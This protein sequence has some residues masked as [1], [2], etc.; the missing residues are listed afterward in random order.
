MSV[1]TYF[2]VA[3]A[4]LSFVAPAKTRFDIIA[5][6]YPPFSSSEIPGGGLT[7]DLLRNQYGENIVFKP[8]F[9]P[10]ARAAK[11]LATSDWCGS[12]FPPGEQVPALKWPLS[13][14]QIKI[15]L[16]RRKQADDF[17]WTKLSELSGSV[18]LL[19]IGTDSPFSRQFNDAGL[20]IVW[21]ESPEQGIE[22]LIKQRV[23]YSMGDDMLGSRFE[24]NSETQNMLQFSDTVLTETP[25][26]LFTNPSC[27][28]SGLMIRKS[29]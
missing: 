5:V 16:Y 24:Q 23:D 22:L 17:R 19:R 28:I 25:V 18:A 7:F 1:I 21:V 20:N 29:T 9:L 3:I 26:V 8:L 2:T 11:V 10:P 27:E 15:G 14:H 6:E 4:M 12:F 13:E